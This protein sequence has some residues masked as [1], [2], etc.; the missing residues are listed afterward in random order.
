MTF[1]FGA[2]NMC[3]QPPAGGRSGSFDA[4]A[5]KIPERH[6]RRSSAPTRPAPTR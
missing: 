1:A 2:T 4:N 3:L 6:G 5:I